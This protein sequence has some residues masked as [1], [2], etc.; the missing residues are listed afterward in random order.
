MTRQDPRAPRIYSTGWGAV[1]VPPRVGGS[2][3]ATGSKSRER[4]AVRKAPSQV[5]SDFQ[6]VCAL[7]GSPRIDSIRASTVGRSTSLR[8]FIIIF[9]VPSVECGYVEAPPWAKWG[10]RV[11]AA[12][13]ERRTLGHATRERRQHM[14]RTDPGDRSVSCRMAKP[15]M[16]SSQRA[17]ASARGGG[18]P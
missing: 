13:Y 7:S 15:P 6:V 8:Y 5:T 12:I 16:S 9:G 3:N 11:G 18:P 1:L 2:S 14:H 4:A 17:H 10:S